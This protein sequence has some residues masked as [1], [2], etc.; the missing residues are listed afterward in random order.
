MYGLKYG[1]LPI[2]RATGGL[3]EIIQDFDPS[4]RA[5]NGF[6]F[7]DPSP[8]AFWDAIVRARR[9][10]HQPAE[11]AELQRRAMTTDLSWDHAVLKYE[12]LYERTLKGR[13]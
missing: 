10:F 8:E 3:F 11:W 13:R 4:A 7:F 9:H 2:A 5:G 12:A 1:A 6:L